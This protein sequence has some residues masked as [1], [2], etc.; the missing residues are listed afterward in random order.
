MAASAI[1]MTHA[2]IPGSSAAS[3][4]P[5]NLSPICARRFAT[6]VRD[7]KITGNPIGRRR[8]S[9]HSAATC[10]RWPTCLRHSPFASIAPQRIY[11]RTHTQLVGCFFWWRIKKKYGGAMSHVSRLAT[12]ASPN[13]EMFGDPSLCLR[14]HRIRHK[15]AYTIA[16]K[17]FYRD[18]CSLSSL[19]NGLKKICLSVWRIVCCVC[20]MN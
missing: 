8:Q 9:C 2:M 4:G 10:A 18:R 19:F 13:C 11:P 12:S 3:P 1:A 14:H 16:A 15:C 5:L 6:S 20:K 17:Q 7:N